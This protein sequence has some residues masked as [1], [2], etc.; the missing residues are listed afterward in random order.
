SPPS[1]FIC[2]PSS[3]L[4]ITPPQGHSGAASRSLAGLA[5]R[6]IDCAELRVP[7][8]RARGALRS[9]HGVQLTGAAG[10]FLGVR[11]AK[12]PQVVRGLETTHPCE[13]VGLVE[14]T[15]RRAADIN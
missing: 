1:E 3:K 13:P 4:S 14:H 15:A 5:V 7:N 9:R 2:P 12:R 10:R 8:R 6:V 11:G